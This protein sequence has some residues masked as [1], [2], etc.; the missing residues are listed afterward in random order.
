VTVALATVK[1]DIAAGESGV[2]RLA[3]SDARAKR[4]RRALGGRR[5]LVA[6]VQLTAT[7]AAGEP[8]TI[9]RTLSVTG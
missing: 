2:V 9:D 6:R 4:L 1:R 8:T 7:A 3:L 5:G